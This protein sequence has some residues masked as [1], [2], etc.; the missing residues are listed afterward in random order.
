MFNHPRTNGLKK[1]F[2]AMMEL[3]VSFFQGVYR[4][5]S[6]DSETAQLLRVL[7]VTDKP[8][9]S[10]TVNVH[11]LFVRSGW[12]LISADEQNQTV[13]IEFPS[14]LHRA[15]WSF[16]HTRK[17]LDSK[18]KTMSLQEFVKQVLS[19]LNPTNLREIFSSSSATE[20][21]NCL[22][23][24]F[25]RAACELTD[26]RGIHLFPGFN[27]TSNPRHPA[28]LDFYADEKNWSIEILRKGE[29]IEEH[30]ARV[31]DRGVYHPWVKTGAI[32]D[33]VVLDFHGGDAS[34]VY[35]GMSVEF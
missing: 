6:M 14:P 15:F 10:K 7:L 18:F 1:L 12:L 20:L 2:V 35:S 25:Y 5:D 27:T 33:Y 34:K 30:L 22:R 24:E 9:V 4:W 3:S 17:L 23:I 28:R 13:T 16:Y 29:E 8:L 19:R 11:G 26:F 21:E 32:E 31:Q